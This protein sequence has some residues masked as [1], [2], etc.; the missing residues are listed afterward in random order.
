M[1]LNLPDPAI[2]AAKGWTHQVTWE[3][4]GRPC[5]ARCKSRVEAD[6][7]CVDLARE[8]YIT[9]LTDLADPETSITRPPQGVLS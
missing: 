3:V 7:W 5:F 1:N 4:L 8:G 6:R 2:A 9:T